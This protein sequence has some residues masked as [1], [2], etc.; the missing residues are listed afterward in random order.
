[1]TA[2]V[3]QRKPLAKQRVKNRRHRRQSRYRKRVALTRRGLAGGAKAAAKG[4]TR[5]EA[6]EAIID[7]GRGR[8]TP[9]FG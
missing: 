7:L 2:A 3:R 1:M 4:V 5:R 8:R 6:A 9:V